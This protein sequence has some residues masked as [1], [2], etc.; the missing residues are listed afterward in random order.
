VN[1]G[2]LRNGGTMTA[3]N[4]EGARRCINEAVRSGD[5]DRRR[6]DLISGHLTATKADTMEIANWFCAL[7]LAREDF[8]LINTPKSI[9]GHALGAAG[10]I[11]CV[12]VVL[13]LCNS[14]VH[15]SL[16]CEDLHPDLAWCESRI[17]RA[18]IDREIRVAAKAS[19]GF[20]DVNACILFEK[21]N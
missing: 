10:A 2:G 17:P 20:G 9:L 19:F 13:Q 12:A 14:F 15:P 1:C 8:A 3:G 5:I 11:E 18:C 21:L 4:P 6:I 7:G 16:N